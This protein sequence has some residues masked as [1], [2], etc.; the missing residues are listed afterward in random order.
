MDDLYPLPGPTANPPEWAD[1]ERL[2]LHS[3]ATRHVVALVE[4]GHWTR[5]QGLIV[6]AYALS[7]AVARLFHAEIDRRMS[8]TRIPTRDSDF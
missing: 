6:L 3:P 7:D 4:R 1:I 8:E 5:E 2:A